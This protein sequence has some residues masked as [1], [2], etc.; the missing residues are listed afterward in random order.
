MN[1]TI[2]ASAEHEATYQELA[3]LL[4]RHSHLTALEILAIASNMVGKIIAMQDQRTVS[5]EM[6]MEIVNRN[7]ELGN[8]QIISRIHQTQ[9]HA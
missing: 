8:A 4:Q 9:G 5:T 3:A 6:A 2:T 7:I 1:T